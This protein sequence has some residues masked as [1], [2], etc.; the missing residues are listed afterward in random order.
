MRLLPLL[1]ALLLVVSAQAQSTLP[2]LALELTGGPIV[3]EPKVE[4]YLRIETVGGGVDYEGWVGIEIRGRSSQGF[5][6]KGYGF[7]TREVDGE[8][9]NVSLLGMPAEN[10]WVLHGPYAD[11]TYL[12]NAL[13]Y[14]TARAIGA[15]APRSRFCELVVDG[16]SLGIYLLVEKVKRDD[17]RVPLEKLSDDGRRGDFM[18]E[19][20]GTRGALRPGETVADGFLS[21]VSYRPDDPYVVYQRYEFAYPK[22]ADIR[23]EQAGAVE[24]WIT[25]T[26]ALSYAPAGSAEHARFMDRVDAPS[27]IDLIILQEF[28]KNVDAYIFSTYLVRRGGEDGKLYAGPV[29]DFNFAFG[30]ADYVRGVSTEDLRTLTETDSV[31]Q[32]APPIYSNL[33]RDSSFRRALRARW[34][35]LR[36][37]HLSDAAIGSRIDSLLRLVVPYVAADTA[38]YGISGR[39]TWPNEFVGADFYGDLLY[40]RDWVSARVA[41]L[42]RLW[43]A[44]EQSRP[45]GPVPTLF[46]NPTVINRD[47]LIRIAEV[48]HERVGYRV[49]DSMGTLVRV[50]SLERGLR[51]HY[52]L[53][54]PQ[55][56][57]Y[58]VE[59]D[60]AT[61]LLRLVVMD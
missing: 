57:V 60:G 36:R 49:Y 8:N 22:P 15:A 26:E 51:D 30:N 2:R 38:R 11:K 7:E 47:F 34:R 14:T 46:P 25:E 39:Y 44:V 24:E 45:R 21:T 58:L 9:R 48:P 13:A 40:L 4:A 55:S 32:R 43:G 5:A 27:L 33:Y 16:E 17:N 28:G 1:T 6:K 20:A 31:V 10:D 54:P 42:D 37:T 3:D 52:I 53:G 23:A 12:R 61:E 19:A 59:V 18:V 50:G 29:W 35:D 41:Y 56:G